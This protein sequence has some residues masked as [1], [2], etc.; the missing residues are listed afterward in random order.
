MRSSWKIRLAAWV[1]LVSAG[2]ICLLAKWTFAAAMLI[3]YSS[4]LVIGIPSTKKPTASLRALLFLV[5]VVL[6]VLGIW[7]LD[8]EQTLRVF[9]HP[10]VVVLMWGAS[11]YSAFR[12]WKEAERSVTLR[13]AKLD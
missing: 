4:L 8:Y 3:G 6:V 12:M 13:E 7:S 10:A 2:F 11:M 5:V 9:T 1:V